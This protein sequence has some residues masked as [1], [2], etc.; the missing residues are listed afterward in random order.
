M[1]PPVD[2][3]DIGD[4]TDDVVTEEEGEEAI[5]LDEVSSVDDDTVPR[6]KITIDNKVCFFLNCF[7]RPRHSHYNNSRKLWSALEIASG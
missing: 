1:A 3:E 6:Q 2:P 7:Y 5:E 4:D